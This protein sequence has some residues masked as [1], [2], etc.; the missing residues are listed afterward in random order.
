MASIKKIVL[1]SFAFICLAILVMVNDAKS[2]ST[3]SIL[4][5]GDGSIAGTDKIQK[6]GNIYNLTSSIYGS[7]IVVQCNN[8][9]FDGEGFTLQGSGIWPT[10]PAIN[11]TC[12]NVTVQN[13]SI[14]KWEVGI[15][16][17]YNGNIISNNSVTDC[18]RGIA[19]YA[20]GYNVT[21]NFVENWNIGIRIQGN[22][23]TIFQNQIVNNAKGVSITNSTGI[24]IVANSFQNNVNA[25]NTGN[26][27]Y[28]VY[29]NNFIDQNKDFN[30]G[31]YTHILT[32]GAEMSAL[33]N[34]YPSGG[35]YYNDYTNRY[36]NATEIDSSGIGN[37]PY[38]VNAEPKVVD[39]YPLLA[40]FN[41]SDAIVELPSP[42]ANISQTPSPTLSNSPTNPPS[43]STRSTPS[44]TVE[45][46]SLPLLLKSPTISPNSFQTRGLPQQ[47]IVYGTTAAVA[48]VVMIAIAVAL[49]KCN[50]NKN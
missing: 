26:G 24:T 4:I 16:G 13:F 11:L 28:R 45:V 33:D 9:I 44:P 7:P 42:T 40:P 50:S 18:E 32:T 34:G 37:I 8:I 12:S 25:I 6:N 22:Y 23:S 19:I 29:H 39:R 15:L 38:L 1:L 49:Q 30:G 46:T 43:P 21:G 36:P 31:W 20:D 41:I 3:G 47:Q 5:S 27:G 14:N 35:N 10:P 17:A 48:L 2:Q